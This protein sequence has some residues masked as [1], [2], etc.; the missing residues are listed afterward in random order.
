MCVGAISALARQ[1]QGTHDPMIAAGV[2]APRSSEKINPRFRIGT[3]YGSDRAL[4]HG[5]SLK[6]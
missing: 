4:G 6:A 1:P 2:M 3:F 5:T